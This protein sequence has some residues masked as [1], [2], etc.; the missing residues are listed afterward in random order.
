MVIVKIFAF[1]KSAVVKGETISEVKP[2]VLAAM[3][4]LQ[5]GKK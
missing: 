4:K 3:D 1:G 2:E 5:E